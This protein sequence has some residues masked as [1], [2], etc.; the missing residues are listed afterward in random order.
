MFNFVAP[1]GHSVDSVLNN[2]SGHNVS[3][4]EANYADVVRGEDPVPVEFIPDERNEL[5]NRPLTVFFN[6]RT[7][8]PAH[9]V[10]TALQDA[11]V[12]NAS[13]SCIQRQSSG[14]IVLTFRNAR[15]KDQFLSH[16]VLKIRDQPFALQD[17]DHPLTYMQVFDAPHEMPDATIIQRLAKFCDVVHHRQFSH[18]RTVRLIVEEDMDIDALQIAKSLPDYAENITGIVPQFG[19]KCFDITLQTAEAAIKLAT[20][21]FDDEHTRKPLRLFGAKSVHVSIFVSVEFPDENILNLIEKYDELTS[22]K[23]RRLHFQEEGFTHIERGVQVAEFLKITQD[24]P[25]KIVLA[26][27]EVGFKYSGQPA[28]CYCC[29]STETCGQRLP[30]TPSL[31]HPLGRGRAY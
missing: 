25:K 23:L 24:I 30:E 13:V 19:G 12:D 15:A 28:T 3:A 17:I 7:R 8:V 6:P 31:P 14:E 22:R 20:E 1:S 26:G 10:F 2:P 5:P 21:G 18:R 9:E 27:I 29:Q 11:N 16:N 4:V